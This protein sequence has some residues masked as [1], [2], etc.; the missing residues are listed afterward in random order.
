[1]TIG[2]DASL[3]ECKEEGYTMMKYDGRKP[4]DPDEP[5]EFFAY[6]PR[7]LTREDH[8]NERIELFRVTLSF[9]DL[10][11]EYLERKAAIDSCTEA[12][13]HIDFDNPGFYDALHLADSVDAYC[14][15]LRE[16]G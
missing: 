10:K 13:L 2:T 6:F 12:H 11:Q 1:M 3:L 16:I 4:F 15:I 5:Y 8:G 9:N 7:Y 14:G